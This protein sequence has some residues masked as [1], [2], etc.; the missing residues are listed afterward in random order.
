ML[1]RFFLF[2]SVKTFFFQFNIKSASQGTLYIPLVL[3]ENHQFM[4]ITVSL[5]TVQ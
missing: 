4:I 2:R 5:L 1:S 3:T